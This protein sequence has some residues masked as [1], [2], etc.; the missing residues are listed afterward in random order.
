MLI[1]IHHTHAHSDPMRPDYSSDEESDGLPCAMCG[2]HIVPDDP[3]D[4]VQCCG[5]LEDICWECANPVI[6]TIDPNFDCER[7]LDQ[8]AV[9]HPDCRHGTSSYACSQCITTPGANI[10]NSGRLLMHSS[11]YNGPVRHPTPEQIAVHKDR[12]TA[13]IAAATAA[14]ITVRLTATNVAMPDFVV[15]A[16]DAEMGPA[17]SWSHS[18]LINLF[19]EEEWAEAL[20]ELFTTASPASPTST[21]TADVWA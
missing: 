8:T 12:R 15:H 5:C 13:V 19:S 18:A 16:V 11:I 10:F 21:V 1:S 6:V 7:C 3:E 17:F 4:A 20:A 2:V 14:D 9:M